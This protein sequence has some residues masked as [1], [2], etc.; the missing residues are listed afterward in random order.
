MKV[1]Y[2]IKKLLS[3]TIL[4]IQSLHRVSATKLNKIKVWIENEE[5]FKICL[6]I[7]KTI[8]IR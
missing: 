3:M 4:K 6:L 7:N 5:D 1:L 2:A 8:E